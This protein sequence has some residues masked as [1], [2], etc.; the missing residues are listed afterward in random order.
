MRNL[1]MFESLWRRFRP[2][3]S[4]LSLNPRQ[5][6]RRRNRAIPR[7]EAL[8]DRLTPTNVGTTIFGT[9][10]TVIKTNTG[11]INL[12]VVNA[13]FEQ[14]TITT[15]GGN[16]INGSTSP[17]TNA[18]PVTSI[19]F[20]L[21][22]GSDNLTLDGTANGN[23][24]LPAG[25]QIIGTGGDKTISA[26][27]VYLFGKTPLSINLAGG[28]NE[29]ATFTDV[30]VSGPAT[31]VHKGAGTTN[32]TIQA[33]S[34]NPD[35]VNSW[36][37]LSV[38]N[39]TGQDLNTITDTNFAGNVVINNGPGDGTTGTF[40]G[41]HNIFSAS[42]NQGLLTVTGGVTIATSTGQSNTEVF[43]YNV[44]GTLSINAGAGKTN[45]G[46]ANYV[47]IEDAVTVA[48][49]IPSLGSIAITGA[50][51][52]N[53]NPGLTVD[54]G[55]NSAGKDF[56]VVIENALSIS[57]T[58]S[59]AA[60]VILNDLIAN[61]AA[62]SVTF[63]KTTSG[64]TLTVHAD[65]DGVVSQ[66]GSLLVTSQSTKNSTYNIQTIIGTLNISNAMSYKF[67]NGAD[68]INVGSSSAPGI[69]TVGT[70]FGIS[71]TGGNKNVVMQNTTLGSINEMMTSV[72]SQ[73]FDFIDTNVNGPAAFTHKKKG[74]TSFKVETSSNNVNALNNWNS[75]AITNGVGADTNTI[76]DT[77]FAGGV[78][79]NNGSG[80]GSTGSGGGS[81]N[82][83]HAVNY[84]TLLDIQGGLI[85]STGTG[86]S[87]T[88]VYDYNVH[89]A[90]SVTTGSGIASQGTANLVGIEDN[91]TNS[92]SG[93]PV[94]GG[95]VTITGSTVK[96][97][98][99]GLTVNMGT[100]GSNNFPLT[101]HNSLT[102]SAG[103]TGSANITLNDL[104]VAQGA[105]TINFAR[106]T[107]GNT[108]I[109]QGTSITSVYN[110]FNV[111][112]AATG[113]NT[114]SFQD[115]KGSTQ[116]QGLVSF[117]LGA[118]DDTVNLAS[119]VNN[120]GGVKNADLE[121]YAVP[122]RTTPAEF[123]DGAAGTN[124]LFGIGAGGAL[125]T[126]VFFVTPPTFINFAIF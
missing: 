106:T 44:K 115:Q 76:T 122:V 72:G 19:V 78:T 38:T 22:G 107:S 108:L 25:L 5:P 17:F 30:N 86:Q 23:I 12:T 20:K 63:G 9:T 66:L 97:L 118:G 11:G 65:G 67:G 96:N 124:D 93:I 31:I 88:D 91:Q 16:T 120:K 60:G 109:V 99:P 21:G 41:S 71:A 95:A 32:L 114:Y 119:D 69:V 40:G 73:T 35:L 3:S 7:L 28:G 10:L 84:P 6:A 46:T 26:Q 87:T 34:N 100:D 14:Y 50:A 42:L 13:G 103:G 113:A 112:S 54:I 110:A 55:T 1:K 24:N 36:S 121:F 126:T 2:W 80:D 104:T 8:E 85:V 117:K 90:L 101:L 75:L 89:G 45:Q 33:S 105:T 43:D 64:N 47:G 77:D 116:I 4:V 39:G 62:V 18:I 74:T 94:I 59:G 82:S 37:G 56:P 53:L 51:V 111:N 29:T 102:V 15:S 125:G 68:T 123:F 48:G 81:V 27:Q 49:N 58:G 61:T 79:I 57:A 83:I 70:A 98:N 52:A 92:G